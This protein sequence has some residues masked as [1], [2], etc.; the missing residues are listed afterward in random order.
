MNLAAAR[1]RHIASTA[2]STKRYLNIELL[3]NQQRLTSRIADGATR[4]GPFSFTVLVAAVAVNSER[5]SSLAM[6][7]MLAT[8][9]QLS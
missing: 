8:V 2:W 3:K 6:A 7:A 5:A 9:P 1:L 4:P